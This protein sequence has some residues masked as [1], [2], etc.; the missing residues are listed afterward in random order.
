[1][2]LFSIIGVRQYLLT[3]IIPKQHEIIFK[4][5]IPHHWVFYADYD[6]YTSRWSRSSRWASL[7]SFSLYRN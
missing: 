3:Y 6:G 1:M 5:I 4:Y 7:S 2:H